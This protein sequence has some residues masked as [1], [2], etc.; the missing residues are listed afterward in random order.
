M[1]THALTGARIL[2]GS[3]SP[4]LQMAEEI[5][6][7]HHEWWDG[8]GYPNGLKGQHIPISGRIVAVA[9]VFDALTHERPYKPAWPVAS[10]I[11]EIR[12]LAG[13]QFDPAVVTA[14]EDLHTER[15]LDPIE[16]PL[17]TAV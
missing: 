3:S 2:A 9:D 1:K 6:L 4:P 10:A 14:L 11:D 15:L 13:H 5:A 8:S 12:L 17:A 7:T 16:L